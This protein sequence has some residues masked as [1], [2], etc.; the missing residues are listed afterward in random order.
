VLP[1]LQWDNQATAAV[2]LDTAPLL[3]AE[4]AARVRSAVE[5]DGDEIT[6]P[7]DFDAAHE[8][9]RLLRSLLAETITPLSAG[10]EPTAAMYAQVRSHLRERMSRYPM[11]GTIVIPTGG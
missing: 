8:R 9:N 7:L 1:F 11:S 4:L 6:D 5:A 2:L 3:P 10:G